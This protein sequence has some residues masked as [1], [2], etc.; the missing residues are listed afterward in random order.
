MFSYMLVRGGQARPCQT[1]QR[2]TYPFQLPPV[3]FLSCL[4]IL[5]VSWKCHWFQGAAVGLKMDPSFTFMNTQ[6]MPTN[7]LGPLVLPYVNNFTKLFELP[8][9]AASYSITL[10][11]LADGLWSLICNFFI[12]FYSGKKKGYLLIV[13]E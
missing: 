6:V 8:L 2:F 3:S 10:S 5:V 1:R 9:S 13:P 4:C 7:S 11:T 12:I